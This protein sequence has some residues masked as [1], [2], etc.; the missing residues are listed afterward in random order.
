MTR[1]VL[2]ALSALL[3]FAAKVDAKSREDQI[4]LY[5]FT[6]D[7]CAVGPK[8][9]QVDAKREACVQL[10]ARSLKP[11][12]D[13]KRK[14]WLDDMND[15]DL[16]CALKLYENTNCDGEAVELIMLP[17]GVT[18]CHTSG[19]EPIRSAKFHCANKVD[20]TE[21]TSVVTEKTT[22]G[23]TSWSI[24]N[25]ELPTPHMRS[26]VIAST[27]TVTETV[28][29]S[30]AISAAHHHLEPR[31]AEKDQDPRSVWMYHP[32]SRTVICYSCHTTKDI[33]DYLNFKCESG[34]EVEGSH[35][36]SPRDPPR[37]GESL[38]S[39][40]TDGSTTTLTSITDATWTAT[41]S[42]TSTIEVGFMALESWLKDVSFR[43]PWLGDYSICARAEWVKR[44]EPDYEI[45][46][47]KVKLD[48]NGLA[49]QNYFSLDLPLAVDTEYTAESTTT[50][51]G[52]Y[53]VE[54]V[55][56]TAHTISTAG[57]TPESGGSA[58]FPEAGQGDVP[59]HSDL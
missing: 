25:D 32:W 53:N 39:T 35:A 58:I 11:A 14:K 42:V 24:G 26:K 43:N 8:G 13:T 50:R 16:Q 34:P 33:G 9:A 15:G 27:T 54:T 47:S 19:S 31:R 40:T 23:L 3:A 52:Y 41:T 56:V 22:I 51:T 5:Q 28:S 45:R 38:G 49:C 57:E 36:C 7:D 18:E 30:T 29:T 6:A 10:D 59:R 1:F 46:L 37:F 2:P 48:E 20:I 21:I 4:R 12:I 17:E 44:G 55:T